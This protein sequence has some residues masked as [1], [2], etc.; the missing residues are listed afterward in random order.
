LLNSN[1]T[2]KFEA[3]KFSDYLREMFPGCLT[4]QGVYKMVNDLPG[5]GI[6]INEKMAAKYPITNS[7]GELDYLQKGWY[8]HQAL[9]HTIIPS[10]ILFSGGDFN[11]W[12]L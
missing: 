11:C 10:G 12:I 5:L 7:A 1:A 4:K 2:I 9:K 6:D 8:C 3:K